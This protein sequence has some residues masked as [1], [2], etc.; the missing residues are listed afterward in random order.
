MDSFEKKSPFPSLKKIRKTVK[1]VRF[2]RYRGIRRIFAKG[3]IFYV[4]QGGIITL[5]LMIIEL[6]LKEIISSVKVR[7]SPIKNS[8]T[9]VITCNELDNREG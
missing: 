1:N 9:I 7:P 8:I 6:T 3:G 5:P 2:L 4:Q